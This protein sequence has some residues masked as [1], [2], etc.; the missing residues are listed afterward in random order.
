MRT[1]EACNL[2]EGALAL[3]LDL[4][5]ALAAFIFVLPVLGIL[6]PRIALG[7]VVLIIG[8]ALWMRHRSRREEREAWKL[9][10]K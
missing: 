6:G 9:L 10:R 1:Y 3:V 2:N 5:I 7:A 8:L 4:A